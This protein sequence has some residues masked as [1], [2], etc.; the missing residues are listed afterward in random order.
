VAD[1]IGPAQ[2]FDAPAATDPGDIAK[3]DDER[4]RI[5]KAHASG[6]ETDMVHARQYSRRGRT[7]AARRWTVAGDA[8][9]VGAYRRLD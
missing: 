6:G 1:D 2:A 3:A 7:P 9:A 5:G 8:E 4:R